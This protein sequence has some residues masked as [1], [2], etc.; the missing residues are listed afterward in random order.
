MSQNLTFAGTGLSP[1]TVPN[2]H[3]AYGGAAIQYAADGTS[4]F[5]PNTDSFLQLVDNAICAGICSAEITFNWNNAFAG[6]EVGFCLIDGSR[7]GASVIIT[8]SI[9]RFRNETAGSGGST[10]AQASIATTG[11]GK[12]TFKFE[13]DLSDGSTTIYKNGVSVLTGVYAGPTTGLRIGAQL[14]H[15]SDNPVQSFDNLITVTST[16][17]KT[18]VS[19]NG[20]A[21]V[22]VGSA[23]NTIDTLNMSA[24]TGLTIGGKAM[25]NLV[26]N[27]FDAPPFVDG[28]V[29]A[30]IGNR[31]AIASDSGGSAS[32]S[33]QLLPPVGW[34][35]QTLE[36]PLNTTSGVI[37]GLTPAAQV[38]E[39]ILIETVNGLITPQGVYQGDVDGT[40]QVVRIRLDGTVDIY[41]AHT[42]APT[43]DTT[44]NAFGF[45]TPALAALGAT[46]TSTNTTIS[47]INAAAAVS[48]TGGLVSINGGAFVSSGTITNG[49][50]IA[51]R[52]TAS[53][54]Y[55]TAVT[56][57]VNIGGVSAQFTAT[58]IADPG[59]PPDT[60][61]DSI[62]FPANTNCTP[63][64]AQSSAVRTIAGINTASPIT[65]ATNCTYSVAGGAAT[66]A[67]GSISNGQTIQL[68]AVASGTPG[69]TV[70]ASITIGGQVFTW[71][72]TTNLP[73]V[74][75]PTTVI[76]K[77]TSFTRPSTKARTYY[78]LTPNNK[79]L[80]QSSP[81]SD[82]TLSVDLSKLEICKFDIGIEKNAGASGL[83][84]IWAHEVTSSNYTF[85]TSVNLSS[86]T[87]KDYTPIEGPFDKFKAEPI[88]VT[89]S[90][91]FSCV[92]Y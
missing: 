42:V 81:E 62:S 18:I 39:Q 9:V 88:G 92:A 76:K 51:A 70:N 41:Q 79:G 29:Y 67:N 90:F 83:V 47:G 30:L 25:T 72:V 10:I 35:V 34:S 13:V 11:T 56:A 12:V 60:T 65:A 85:I 73:Q 15:A 63:N 54:S 31:T 69:A 71:V 82:R 49:Q 80:S 33:T 57:T 74:I 75:T 64:S 32:R 43:T 7:T 55:S 3:T 17:A 16:T 14:Y 58:T 53:N 77:N 48:V 22:R 4:I 27:T 19:I 21:G 23:G 66:S 46:V 20:G 38:G 37:T 61:P 28:Q 6:N 50:T 24:L 59:P 68:F 40:F 8:P 5:M 45:N 78:M 86:L 89:G 2:T 44:P 84:E 1:Y 36:A 91:N 52:V 87:E 26:G